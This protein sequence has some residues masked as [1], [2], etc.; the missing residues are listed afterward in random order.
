MVGRLGQVGEEMDR[1]IGQIEQ[2]VDGRGAALNEELRAR[3]A[4]LHEFYEGNGLKL[5]ELL[6]TR[7]GEVVSQIVAFA[8]SAVGALSGR[9]AEIIDHLS[10]RQDEIGGALDETHR[11]MRES[12]ERVTQALD[13]A[14]ANS[15]AAMSQTLDDKTSNSVATLTNVHEQLKS[16]V[17]GLIDGMAQTHRSLTG[18]I[19]QAETGLGRFDA[20]LGPQIGAFAGAV[21]A[22]HEELGRLDA[23]AQDGVRRADETAHSIGDQNRVLAAGLREMVETQAS[24]DRTLADR[25]HTMET[26]YEEAKT[27]Q[28]EF[29]QRLEGYSGAIGRTLAQAEGKARDVGTFLSEAA[30]AT[31]G[32][33]T[34]QYDELRQNA[35]RERERSSAALTAAY[36]QN[37]GEMNHL[38]QQATERYKAVSQELRAMTGEIQR[39]LETT[40]QELRRGALELPRETSEQA[41]AMRRVVA[42]QIKALNELT[43]IVARSGR[44]YDISEPAAPAR[45]EPAPRR[46]PRADPAPARQNWTAEPAAAS[47]T[48]ARQT[49]SEPAAAAG[50]AAPRREPARAEA[51]RYDVRPTAARAPVAPAAAPE[52][53]G[54]MSDLLARAS[55]DEQPAR[56]SSDPLENL[57]A[58]IA[59]VVDENGLVEAWDRYRR[60]DRNAFGRRLYTTQGTK[61]FEEVRR[62]YGAEADFRETVDRYLAEFERLLGEIDRDDRDGTM[63]RSYLTSETGKVY[64]LLADASGRLG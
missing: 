63:T 33:L 9:S 21:E 15:A 26:F 20:A 23:N 34:G 24:I 36:E 27:R 58:E 39:E 19:Q 5:I 30:S 55:Q 48:T 41:A 44:M 40:R 49:W 7:G 52:R 46:E 43:D 47:A 35:T 17:G 28:T 25:L 56:R 1:R 37:L 60:G 64:T 4:E 62:R 6:T 54:W 51:P 53:G 3:A 61:T 8:E 57:S 50:P 18:L 45:P 22:L 12:L 14:I 31:A 38:F 2:T 13:T 42:E 32:A 16:Q 10:Q 29:E 11:G 59:R